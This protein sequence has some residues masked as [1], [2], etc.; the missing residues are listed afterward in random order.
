MRVAHRAFNTQCSD[1]GVPCPAPLRWG[2]AGAASVNTSPLP[3]PNAKDTTGKRNSLIQ[4]GLTEHCSRICGLG[5]RALH[6]SRIPGE[7]LWAYVFTSEM[8]C[9]LFFAHRQEAT[10]MKKF[11]IPGL[12]FFPPLNLQVKCY[13]NK[14][15]NVLRTILPLE[16]FFPVKKVTFLKWSV[17]WI[18]LFISFI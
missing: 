6:T 9:F 7:P 14:N 4:P 16:E 5:F 1:C 10:A 8:L 12:F 11:R 17:W 13:I 18:H 15:L 2:R 3:W